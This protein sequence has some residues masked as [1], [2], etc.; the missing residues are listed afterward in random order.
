M[1]EPG[2]GDQPHELAMDAGC[3]IL[4]RVTE[5][6]TNRPVAKAFFWKSPVDHPDQLEHVPASTFLSGV[7]RTDDSGLGRAVVP[8]E[9]GKRYVLRFA[10]IQEPNMPDQIN[11][12]MAKTQGYLADPPASRPIELIGGKTIRL[13]FELSKGAR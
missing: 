5:A 3:E 9:P 7:L 6:G 4:V 12:A 11:A 13:R 2:E 1:V 8:P 10:G